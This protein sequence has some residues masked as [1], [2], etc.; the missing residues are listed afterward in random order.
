[1]IAYTSIASITALAAMSPGPDFA[2]SF[3]NNVS[4]GVRAGIYTALGIGAGIV[5]HLLYCILGV[6]IIVKSHDTALTVLKIGAAAYMS[7]LGFSILL[8]PPSTSKNNQQSN[9]KKH[10]HPFFEGFLCNALNPKAT[11]FFLSMYTRFVPD[12]ASLLQQIQMGAVMLV[13][14]VTWFILFSLFLHYGIPVSVM[15]KIQHIVEKLMGVTLLVLA[16]LFLF[17]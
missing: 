6:A 17:E 2:L 14:V 11:L 10:R 4:Q 15:R 8:P 3:K 13:T 7:W 9:I 12:G 16:G 1:M 5:V